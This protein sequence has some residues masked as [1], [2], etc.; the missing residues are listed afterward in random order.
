MD[1]SAEPDTLPKAPT[2]IA[3]FDEITMGG[4]P[5][6]RPSLICGAAGC[7]KTLFGLTF[8]VNGATQYDEPGVF[9]SFEERGEDLAA[10]VRSLRFDL[11]ALVAA[12]KLVIDNIK[13]E[14]SDIQENGDYNL[15]GLFVRLE[16]AVDSIG[17]KRVVL[18][19]VETLFGGLNNPALL[20]SELRRLFGWTKDHGLTTIIT[21]ERDNSDQLTRRG[22]EEYV[23]DFVAVLDNRIQNQR[24]TRRLFIM[25]YRGSAHGADEYP[26]LIDQEGIKLLPASAT[27]LNRPASTE[28]VS[29][30]IR[31]LD[32]MFEYGGWFRGSSVL[33]SGVAGSGKTAIASLFV[34]AASARGE[35]CMF[36]GLEEGSEEI[37]RNARSIGIDLQ[38]WVDEGL[39]RVEASRPCRYGLETHLMRIHRDLDSFQPAVVVVDPISAFRGPDT[40][41]HMALLRMVNLLKMRGITAVFTSLQDAGPALRG[42]DHDLASLMDVWLRLIDVD[43][44]GSRHNA[45]YIVKSRGMGHCSRVRQFRLSRAGLALVPTGPDGEVV[46]L[47]DMLATQEGAQGGLRDETPEGNRATARIG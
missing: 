8:L 9:M 37:C 13:V 7:G 33:V 28:V 47:N 23:S 3:G 6:G 19:T 42:G 14:P 32:D 15:D 26:F 27:L 30:G 24:A 12:G 43:A 45:L 22:L 5:A 2:G 16:Y 36:F 44:D 17:A 41:V 11:D 38:R 34:D 46:R 25:K 20:R 31:D 29:T 1:I 10:N 40:D 18:D 4:L 21:G 39:L 35:R